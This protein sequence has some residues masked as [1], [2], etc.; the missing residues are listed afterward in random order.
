MYTY[1]HTC[2]YD[3]VCV[4]TDIQDR[5]TDGRTDGPTYGHPSRHS[6]RHADRQTERQTDRETDRQTCINACMSTCMRTLILYVYTCMFDI[7][8]FPLSPFTHS[9]SVCIYA[10]LACFAVCTNFYTYEYL[11]IQIDI[12]LDLLGSLSATLLALMF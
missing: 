5:R 1:L 12:D 9:A 10:Y 8:C 11:H 7:C 2:I 6:D 3:Y 4:H